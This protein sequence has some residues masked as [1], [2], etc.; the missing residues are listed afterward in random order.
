MDSHS[1]NSHRQFHIFSHRALLL[2]IL[3]GGC[4]GHSGAISM[5]ASAAPP[6]L[7]GRYVDDYGNRYRIGAEEWTQAPHGRFH[8]V[9]WQVDRMYLIA[10]ND[11]ANAYAPGKWTR[12][13]WMRFEGMPPYRWG[14]C[15]TA[16]EAP[17]RAAAESTP[18]PDRSQPRTGCGGYPFSRMAIDT[19]APADS[20]GAAP[21]PGR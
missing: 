14:F 4:G 5:P 9:H 11:A 12:I 1:F 13:D 2:L 8:I 19:L 3:L 21:T 16:Y 20:T 7:L 17:T 15:L 6:E 10:W 18:A